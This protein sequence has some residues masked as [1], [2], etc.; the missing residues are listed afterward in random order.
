MRKGSSRGF[1]PSSALAA[2]VSVI[3]RA[4]ETD[5][6]NA[7][8]KEWSFI[9]ATFREKIQRE[10]LGV[11]TRTSAA[12]LLTRTRRGC[13]GSNTIRCIIRPKVATTSAWLQFWWYVSVSRLPGQDVGSYRTL[14]TCGI[15]LVPQQGKGTHRQ[16][17]QLLC[18]ALMDRGEQQTQMERERQP[19]CKLSGKLSTPSAWHTEL[20]LQV[21]ETRSYETKTKGRGGYRLGEKL[22][23]ANAT[24]SDGVG[25][26]AGMIIAPDRHLTKLTFGMLMLSDQKRCDC[27]ANKCHTCATPVM[28]CKHQS[29]IT[30]SLHGK[31]KGRNVCTHPC[32]A[33]ASRTERSIKH[34]LSFRPVCTCAQQQVTLGTTHHN[35]AVAHTCRWQSLL[36]SSSNTSW[37]LLAA[38]RLNPLPTAKRQA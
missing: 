21:E 25:F 32:M 11:P 10:F 16:G 6:Y 15:L 22:S 3:L 34:H 23:G 26:P 29:H 27:N 30:T 33:H 12:Q 5:F 38:L 14:G 13:T 24:G 4:H 20:N 9:K 18:R 1:S 2:T 19:T 17:P 37:S 28:R 8:R 36:D 35:I 31:T 7:Y